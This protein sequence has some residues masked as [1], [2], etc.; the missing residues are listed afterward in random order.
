M[1]KCAH[2]LEH[3]VNTRQNQGVCKGALGTPREILAQGRIILQEFKVILKQVGVFAREGT[4]SSE[5][6]KTRFQVFFVA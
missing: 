2:T 4:Y 3:V 5:K 6:N 1:N